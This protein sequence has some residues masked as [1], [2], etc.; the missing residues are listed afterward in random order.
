LDDLCLQNHCNKATL[1]HIAN[2]NSNVEE[3][4][5]PERGFDMMQAPVQKVDT[6]LVASFSPIAKQNIGILPAA[7]SAIDRDGWFMRKVPQWV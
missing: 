1:I 2:F 5:L 3:I 4:S 7:V 6:V